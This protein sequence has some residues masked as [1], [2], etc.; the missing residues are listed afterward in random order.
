MTTPIQASLSFHGGVETVTGSRFLVES[1]RSRVLLDCGLFQ[2]GREMRERNWADPP[3]APTSIDAVVLT[4]AHLDH[5]GYLPVLVRRGFRGPIHCT[6]ASRDLLDILLHDSARIEEADAAYA[7][8]KGYSRHRPALPLFETADVDRVLEQV[9]VHRYHQ[10]FEAAPAVQVYFR[11]SGHI[12]GSAIVELSFN[13]GAKLVDTGDLGRW[14]QPIFH[15]PEPSDG[16]DVVLVES[17]YG[18]RVHATDAVERLAQCIHQAVRRGGPLLIPAFAVGRAQS[19]IWILR[20]LEE[21]GRIPV[22]PVYI[23]SPMANRVSEVTCRHLDDLDGD[24]RQAMDERRCPLCCKLYHL[25]VTKEESIALNALTG[26]F[27][28][29]AGSG[30]ITGGRILHHLRQ[31]LPDERTTVLLPGFQADGTRGRQLVDGA[32][33]VRIH[34]MEVRVRAHVEVINGLSAHA[35][36]NDILRWLSLLKSPPK[37]VYVIHGEPKQAGA[38]AEGIRTRFGW[39]VDVARHG[40]RVPLEM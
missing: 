28:L 27:I 9:D 19:L 4:H 25:V 24:M 37:R 35:D 26:T 30:M 10:S 33:Q 8:R 22:L 38:L 7:N 39:S 40:Q 12:L 23:D 11:R 14:N 34:G 2:G 16:G 20:E 6:P 1:G 17:T 18:D 32:E 21:S 3:F 36:R 5:S 31:R 13:G 15:D 29:I